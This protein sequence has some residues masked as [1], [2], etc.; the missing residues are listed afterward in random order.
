M[1]AYPMTM[2]SG[3]SARVRV[4][5]PGKHIVLFLGAALLLLFAAAGIFQK[6]QNGAADPGV[7]GA[8]TAGPANAIALPEFLVDLA[9]D[10]SGRISYIR[11]SVSVMV[12]AKTGARGVER[13]TA[14]A[15]AIGERI[16]FL[17]RGL[18]PEDFAGEAAMAR[19]KA[20]LLRRVNLVIAPDEAQ[21]V[22]INDIVIQ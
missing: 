4:R 14:A 22:I 8:A 12:P 19:V 10:S 3:A 11:L 15:P 18:S 20:E 13:V 9:P 7:V 5:T 17:L 1:A 6:I 2:A 21:D 16:N